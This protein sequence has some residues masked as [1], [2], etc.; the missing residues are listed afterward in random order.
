MSQQTLPISRILQGKNPREY[1]DPDEMAELEEGIRVFGVIEPIIVR[2]IPNT[3]Q[4][5]IIAGERRW[6]AAKNVFGDQYAMPVV[7]KDVNDA[8]AEAMAVIENYH[9]A[10]MSVAE[11]ARAA[12]RQLLRHRGDKQETAATMGWSPDVLERRLALLA[13]TPAVLKALTCRQILIGHAELLAGIPPDK[14]DTVL[15]GIITHK[16][17]VAALK[18]QLGQYARRLAD[19]V[20]DTA[21][22]VGCPYNS[23]RQAGL[24]NES[25]GEGYCQHPAHFDE[26][27]MK[28]VE[29]RAQALR[30]EYPV[31]RIVKPSDGFTPLAV[32]ADGELGVGA[33]QY[34]ACKGC[35]SFGCAVSAMPG[36]YGRVTPSLCFDAAC[37]SQKV[38][39]WRKARRAAQ[40]VLVVAG[41]G[42]GPK[43]KAAFS[44]AASSS[45]GPGQTKRQRSS[46]P[47]NQT[48]QRVIDHRIAQWRKWTAHALMTQPERNRRVL[49]ALAR[50]GRTGDVRVPEFAQAAQKIAGSWVVEDMEL[51][52]CLRH[53]DAIDIGLLDKLVLAVTAAAA[54]GVDTRDLEL[55]LN[56]LEV[57]EAR[58]FQW[59][60][61]FLEL[62]TMSE[63]ESLAEEVGLK[64][65]MGADFKAARSGKKPDFVA[66][67]LQ[68]PGF[69]YRGTVPAVM[70]YPRQAVPAVEAEEGGSEDGVDPRVADGADDL[71]TPSDTEAALAV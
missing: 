12:Q 26:L 55:L 27:M 30:D 49:I 39:Q 54:F 31:I 5:E 14:Q 38:A 45:A 29:T 64:K 41:Q 4:F 1:F 40:E 69:A 68:V 70:R 53:A 25:L 8:S 71:R 46:K 67:L 51:A 7:I 21:Q 16:V 32:T 22:C 11:E 10:A 59:D 6:R 56:Y 17:P 47:S 20:F 19:A 24:F 28:E 60:K 13:C 61:T 48:P 63:L 58:Y 65:A 34:G 50:S 2:P 15:A 42:G 62:F 52:S 23:A 35:Q 3:D 43:A 36:S 9:R 37:N 44:G 66:A 18:A 33:E 57:D